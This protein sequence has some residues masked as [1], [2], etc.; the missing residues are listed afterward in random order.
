[1]KVKDA[2]EL[3]TSPASQEGTRALGEKQKPEWVSRKF[4]GDYEKP[5]TFCV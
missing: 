1:M 4:F 2:A 3:R 5:S